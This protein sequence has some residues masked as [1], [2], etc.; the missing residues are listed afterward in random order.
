MEETSQAFS[1]KELLQKRFIVPIIVK[2]VHPVREWNDVVKMFREKINQGREGTK[3]KPMSH[4]A[5]QRLL[6]AFPDTPEGTAQMFSF[7]CDCEKKKNFSVYFF[8]AT[9]PKKHATKTNTA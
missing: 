4:Y 9:N 7:Y 6:V 2:E 1:M 3:Y 5:V 8:W